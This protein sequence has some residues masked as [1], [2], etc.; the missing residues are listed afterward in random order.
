[1]LIGTQ[2][3]P[4]PQISK[5]PKPLEYVC[6]TLPKREIDEILE[7]A[8]A[9]ISSKKAR[10]FHALQETGR[11]QSEFHVTLIHRASSKTHPELWER[12]T[13]MHGQAGG[14]AGGAEGGEFAVSAGSK[15]GDCKVLLE[16][17]CSI[18]KLNL[19]H[20]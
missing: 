5:K 6:V 20:R 1:M 13:S 9:S 8:F 14:D 16:R 3:Q 4:A 10:F 2:Q 18:S 12:Y 15:M 11:V 19:L 17:V 7:T